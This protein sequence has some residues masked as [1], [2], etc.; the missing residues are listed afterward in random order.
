[1]SRVDSYLRVFED[2]GVDVVSV[3]RTGS[4]HYKIT[5]S[6]NDQQK[7]FIAGS[8]KAEYRA[9]ENFKSEVKRW[10]RSTEKEETLR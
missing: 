7:F 5:A 1:M 8:S 4:C 6:C 3:S 10:K 9:L 2:I